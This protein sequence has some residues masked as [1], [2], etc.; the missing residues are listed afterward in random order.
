MEYELCYN[1][2]DSSKPNFKIRFEGIDTLV[3]FTMPQFRKIDYWLDDRTWLI[4][5]ADLQKQALAK[6][7]E[8][9]TAQTSL[10]ITLE[11][12][13]NYWR[14]LAKKRNIAIITGGITLA[15]SAAL[16]LYFAL[17]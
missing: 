10:A 17:K 5:Q 8:I 2:Q 13:R 16:L 9:T 3:C 12:D 7:E 6:C 11:K 15:T 1:S 4:K 14:K